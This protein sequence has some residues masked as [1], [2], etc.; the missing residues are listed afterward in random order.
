MERRD[1][2][3]LCGLAATAPVAARLIPTDTFDLGNGYGEIIQKF[4][5]ITIKGV[6]PGSTIWVATDPASG[7]SREIGLLT[8]KCPAVVIPVDLTYEGHDYKLR[9]RHPEYLPIEFGVTDPFHGEMEIA[10]SQTFDHLY[11][12]KG[13]GYRPY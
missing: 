8:A 1:F 4:G 2:L 11:F 12:D 3:K 10:I 6:V 13:R 5:T 9:I 7:P